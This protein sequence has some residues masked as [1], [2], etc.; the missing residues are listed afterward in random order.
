MLGWRL[1]AK[2]EGGRGL[3]TSNRWWVVGMV[4]RSLLLSVSRRGREDISAVFS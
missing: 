4:A 2:P 1:A 3:G